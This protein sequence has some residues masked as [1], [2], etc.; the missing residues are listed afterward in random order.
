MRCTRIPQNDAYGNEKK[1]LN[2]KAAFARKWKVEL[3]HPISSFY[4][5]KSK[6]H[7]F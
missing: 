2:M 7:M 6:K 1:V 5:L 4:P 3:S